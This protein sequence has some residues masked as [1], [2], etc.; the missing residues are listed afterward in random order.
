M[1]LQNVSLV[2]VY[3]INGILQGIPYLMGWSYWEETRNSSASF[4]T[5]LFSLSAVPS[6]FKPLVALF[7]DNVPFYGTPRRGYVTF[8]CLLASLLVFLVP[9]Q[10]A[11]PVS[12]AVIQVL[13]EVIFVFTDSALDGIM[14][15]ESKK[16]ESSR[17]A[18]RCSTARY[19]GR[20][21]G[22]VYAGLLAKVPSVPWWT[23]SGV[24]ILMAYCVSRGI[25]E[26]P[27]VYGS[28]RTMWVQY[29]SV[30]VQFMFRRQLWLLGLPVFVFI[31]VPGPSQG[32]MIWFRSHV[33][34]D[35]WEIAFLQVSDHVGAFLGGVLV[36]VL[37]PRVRFYQWFIVS[38]VLSSAVACARGF[39]FPRYDQLLPAALMAFG[40][41]M[42]ENMALVMVTIPFM[43]IGVG[44]AINGYESV[45][46][47]FIRGYETLS[48]VFNGMTSSMLLN[49]TGVES[50][51]GTHLAL[52]SF[53]SGG[54]LLLPLVLLAVCREK[55]TWDAPGGLPA[56]GTASWSPPTE[57]ELRRG[58]LSSDVYEDV[59]L[60]APT[61]TS[62]RRALPD[63][64][65][66]L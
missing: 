2:T 25:H 53:I 20:V 66:F 28:V 59:P 33:G 44:K 32:Y 39:L 63:D 17:L 9:S 31:M 23:L 1:R 29:K 55:P 22:S 12:I 64:T 16:D 19:L 10:F 5:I 13:L 62:R 34:M 65:R 41:E 24:F 60:H 61:V 37:G 57:Q 26:G 56:L 42:I 45:C 14:V 58:S 4:L 48:F 7:I 43:V 30:F 47:S 49:F 6:L 18:A 50:R 36:S 52:A 8:G 21:V 15:V 27:G 46:I 54:L 40:L 11:F 51:Q 35:L 38:C 3:F